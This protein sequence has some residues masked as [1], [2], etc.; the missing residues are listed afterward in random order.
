MI[1][2]KIKSVFKSKCEGCSMLYGSMGQNSPCVYC[3]HGDL[4]SS[5]F[6]S[7]EEFWEAYKS[8]MFNQ[9]MRW[10]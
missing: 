4:N 2:E 10:I 3:R 7:D 9:E 8:K 6:G 5:N 1:I